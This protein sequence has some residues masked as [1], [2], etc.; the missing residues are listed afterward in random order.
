M[1]DEQSES[2]DRNSGNYNSGSG[3]YNSGDFN[4]LNEIEIYSDYIMKRQYNNVNQPIDGMYFC[5]ENIWHAWGN[6]QVYSLLEVYKINRDPKILKSVKL[7]ADNFVPFFISKNFPRKII[8]LSD[9]KYKI[10]IKLWDF[11]K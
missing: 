1:K 5:W 10:E 6:N 3:N 8:V 2:W 11:L 7:W 9:N 4:Y